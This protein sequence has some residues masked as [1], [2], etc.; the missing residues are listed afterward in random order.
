MSTTIEFVHPAKTLGEAIAAGDHL[1]AYACVDA[2]IALFEVQKV[3]AITLPA[4]L[5][6]R[7]N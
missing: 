1:T 4:P 7:L 2:C 6:C 3:A 5:K